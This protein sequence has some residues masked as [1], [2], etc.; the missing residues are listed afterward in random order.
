[1][2]LETYR[3]QTIHP[4]V[5]LKMLEQCFLRSRELSLT[6]D[7]ISCEDVDLFTSR[8][9][10]A[11]LSQCHRWENVSFCMSA[12]FFARL[13][14]VEGRVPLLRRLSL[15]AGEDGD[16]PAMDVF[17]T[18][19]RL[20]EVE[21]DDSMS[22]SDWSFPFAQLTQCR[23]VVPRPVEFY[24]ILSQAQSLTRCNL[25][26]GPDRREIPL[27]D[28]YLHLP[29][30]RDMEWRNNNELDRLILPSLQ[31][32]RLR[33]WAGNPMYPLRSV[34]S[35]FLRSSCTLRVLEIWGGYKRDWLDD[36]LAVLKA[37]PT[38][39]RLLF[40]MPGLV[41]PPPPS[42]LPHPLFA[43]LHRNWSDSGNASIPLVPRLEELSTFLSSSLDT[44]VFVDM[45]KSRTILCEPECGPPVTR[46]R[47]LSLRYDPRLRESSPELFVALARLE[48]E[49]LV[50]D[51]VR[52]VPQS[53]L[54]LS[55]DFSCSCR[56]NGASWAGN[57]S[58]YGALP[59]NDT[60]GHEIRSSFI[61]HMS[62]RSITIK[63]NNPRNVDT[64]HP[65]HLIRSIHDNL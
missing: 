15:A 54:C 52:P 38:I 34:A 4:E 58:R 2:V 8:V 13:A 48:K 63:H 59:A 36:L 49:G 37:A 16:P 44:D 43:W 17:A 41:D 50:M 31:N 11:I 29:H 61:I 1:M 40:E 20:Q 21:F 12:T 65:S 46:L 47:S 32:F 23:G 6:I 60:P 5:D 51:Y 35:L 28:T 14:Q 22:V 10:D 55:A 45:I 39:S 30:V 25:Y 18:A 19:P 62:I 53:L 3:H 27:E 9:F 42:D 24:E 56:Y 33:L 57:N 7:F 64:L 26:I